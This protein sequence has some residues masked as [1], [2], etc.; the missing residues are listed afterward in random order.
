M[1]NAKGFTLIELM[2]VV[3]IIGIILAVAVP[4]YMAYRKGACDTQSG[5]D[6]NSLITSIYRLDDTLE[7]CSATWVVSNAGVAILSALPSPY[8]GWSGCSAKCDVTVNINGDWLEAG[9]N[10]A[11]GTGKYFAYNITT[12]TKT[13]YNSGWTNAGARYYKQATPANAADAAAYNW[14]GTGT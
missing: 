7:G 3:A 14:C 1:K 10:N 4:Y 6:L 2:V 9:A 13:T 12:G 5:S 8:Y 11:V